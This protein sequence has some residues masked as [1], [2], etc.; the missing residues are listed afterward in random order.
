MTDANDY[1]VIGRII[2][3]YGL[4]GWVKVKSFTHPEANFLQYEQCY[5]LKGD[6]KLSLNIETGKVHGKGLVVKFVGYEDR[7]QA[8]AL[9]KLD[10]CIDSDELPELEEGE[11]YWRQL[12]GLKVFTVSE[13][14]EVCLGQIDY[15]FETGSNDV[16]ALKPCE[17]SM[18]KRERL[19]PYRDEVIKSIDLIN[20]KMVVDWDAEF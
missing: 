20:A 17:G 13:S 11:Y 2:D 7:T 5:Y 4:K 9:L 12:Q 8:E 1:L 15:L 16:I 10:L 18:D 3:V 6:K 14:Q 19:L